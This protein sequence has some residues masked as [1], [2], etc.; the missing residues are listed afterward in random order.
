MRCPYCQHEKSKV[1][2]TTK[3]APEASDDAENV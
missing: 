3:N 2:D 1:A